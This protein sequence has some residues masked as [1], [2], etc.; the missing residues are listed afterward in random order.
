MTKSNE[1]K[2]FKSTLKTTRRVLYKKMLINNIYLIYNSYFMEKNIRV[3][4]VTFYSRDFRAIIITKQLYIE[5]SW[6]MICL[7][8]CVCL[9][10][11]NKVQSKHVPRICKHTHTHTQGTNTKP[12]H[13]YK[14]VLSWN[15]M[16]R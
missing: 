3:A 4:I 13:T 16:R 1:C 12:Q 9:E 2:L 8:V 6:F 11:S 7:C 5:F 10:Y 14:H 15:Q